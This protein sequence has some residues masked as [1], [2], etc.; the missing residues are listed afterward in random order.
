MIKLNLGHALPV[1]NNELAR[2]TGAG[3][4]M[5]VAKQDILGFT[6][7]VV[8][9]GTAFELPYDELAENMGKI[10]NMYKRPIKIS[11]N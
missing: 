1:S 5:G 9:M 7:E 4:K 8:K 3:L 11:V 10:A 2:M 6:K